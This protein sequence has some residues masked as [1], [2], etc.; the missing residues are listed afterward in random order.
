MYSSWNVVSTDWGY[1]L[2]PSQ[3]IFD[4]L[5]SWSKELRFLS[6]LFRLD[7]VWIALT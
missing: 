3:P 2:L 7:Q 6:N 4:L 5:H 1:Q